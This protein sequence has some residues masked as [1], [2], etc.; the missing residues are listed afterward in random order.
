MTNCA[1]FAAIGL[2]LLALAPSPEARAQIAGSTC[3]VSTTPA[4]A[5]VCTPW[6]ASYHA[7]L[8]NSAV[9]LKAGPGQIGGVVCD[10]T[11]YVEVFAKPAASVVLGTTPPLIVLHT[12]ATPD[13]VLNPIGVS[14]PTAISIA[15]VSTAGGSTAPATP[16]NCTVFLS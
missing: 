7:A 2:A 5:T 11:A 14:V 3:I 13:F 1:A 8:T 16:P 6:S 15:A 10:A 4:G 9:Q 12:G